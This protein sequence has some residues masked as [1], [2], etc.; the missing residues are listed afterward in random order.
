MDIEPSEPQS[1]LCHK[2]EVKIVDVDDL[3]D[4][5]RDLDIQLSVHTLQCGVAGGVALV[6]ISN[7]TE[8]PGQDTTKL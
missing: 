6:V 3:L 1:E 7:G 4:V 2:V 5:H 8:T